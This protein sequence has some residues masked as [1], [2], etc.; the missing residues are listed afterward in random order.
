MREV[1]NDDFLGIGVT[2]T[3]LGLSHAQHRP[4]FHLL[5]D[6]YLR[7]ED[8]VSGVRGVGP[9]HS[10]RV[11]RRLSG[12]LAGRRGTGMAVRVGWTAVALGATLSRGSG[13]T[14]HSS[15]PRR[16]ESDDAVSPL[17]LA[18]HELL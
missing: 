1:S 4:L 2:G 6:S 10:R 7:S 14:G 17:P 9:G 3:R 8:G 12:R 5:S 11:F 15:D 16:G 18:L 13:G